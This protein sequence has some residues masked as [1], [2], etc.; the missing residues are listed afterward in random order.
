MWTLGLCFSVDL[1]PYTVQLNMENSPQNIRRYTDIF[2]QC[3][4]C[5]YHAILAAP[6]VLSENKTSEAE[7]MLR[8]RDMRAVGS[9]HFS[10]PH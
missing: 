10:I 7:Q 1:R 3:S 8:W 5:P 9:P 4:T 6:D 2:L